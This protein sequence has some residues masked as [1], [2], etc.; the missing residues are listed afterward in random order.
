MKKIN[1]KKGFTLIE[2]LVVVAIIGILA[3][4]VLVSLSGA[5]SRGADAK[6]KSQL[7]ALAAQAEM[8]T[9][10][11]TA[12]AAAE[13]ATKAGTLFNSTDRN[14]GLGLLIR[15][16]ITGTAGDTRCAS[17]LGKPSN[18]VAWAVAA[19]TSTGAWCVDS[20]GYSSD[21]PKGSAAPYTT[22]LSAIA[23]D[24]TTCQ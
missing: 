5:R 6:I 20:T 9:G 18:N 8:Y 19:K 14:G 4:V 7:S 23:A 3:S 16:L 17:A 15:G 22:T 21:F 12:F 24:G 13:C 10:A 2:L 11:G 1:L